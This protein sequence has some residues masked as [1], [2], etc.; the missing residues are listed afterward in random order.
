MRAISCIVLGFVIIFML[1]LILRGKVDLLI[2]GLIVAA[3]TGALLSL[4]EPP[5]EPS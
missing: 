3:A 5:G 4:S 1:I 2:G